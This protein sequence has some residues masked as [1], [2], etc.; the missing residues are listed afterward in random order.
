[1]KRKSHSRARR[2]TTKSVLLLSAIG[3]YSVLSYILPH[4]WQDATAPDD[5]SNSD[6]FSKVKGLILAIHK[7]LR[8]RDLVDTSG[9][10]DILMQGGFQ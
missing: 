10:V 7:V 9:F 4:I 6:Q 3:L 2:A 8:T 5:T 1:M